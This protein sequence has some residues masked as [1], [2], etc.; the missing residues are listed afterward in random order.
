MKVPSGA[1]LAQ[2]IQL[3]QSGELVRMAASMDQEQLAAR[4]GCT[5]GALRNVM[6]R[7][8]AHG[9]QIPTYPELAKLAEAA[10]EWD[11]EPTQ[12]AIQVPAYDAEM[13]LPA[14]GLHTSTVQHVAQFGESRQSAPDPAGTRQERWP[15]VEAFDAVGDNDMLPAHGPGV[16]RSTLLR[17][18]QPVLQW[19]K[20]PGG[21][22]PDEVIAAAKR[23]LADGPRAQPVDPP[24]YPAEDLLSCIVVGDAH[25]GMLAWARECGAPFNIEIAERDLL[26]A[27]DRL[28]ALAPVTSH[29]VLCNIGDFVHADSE[30]GTTTKGTRVDVDSRWPKVVETAIRAKRNCISGLLTKAAHVHDINVRGNH[31]STSSVVLALALAQFYEHEPRVDV[32]TSPGLFNFYRFGQNLLGF[33]HGHT[34]KPVGLAGVMAVRRRKDWGECTHCRWYNGHYHSQRVHEV[35]GV[36]VEHVPTLAALDAWA[37]GQ[38][39]DA[40]REIRLDVFHREHGLI[41]RHIV[42]IGEIRSLQEGL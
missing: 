25:F 16:R 7:A 13:P 17:D 26:T 36:V 21:S 28:V 24:E 2:V 39:Y 11:D 15:H 4:L 42:G 30:A 40:M 19:I 14:I 34:T 31:D 41:R 8:R 12:P 27:V 6:R 3:W 20:N 38:G 1:R 10:S 33:A 18:G 35:N 37:A 9:H 32:D 22:N 23:G 29:A 5:A